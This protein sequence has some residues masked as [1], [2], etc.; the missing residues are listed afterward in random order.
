VTSRYWNGPCPEEPLKRVQHRF[1]PVVTRL[2]TA[3]PYAVD[4]ALAALVLFAMSL[5]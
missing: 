4:L 5:Q 2:R 3:D 1:A